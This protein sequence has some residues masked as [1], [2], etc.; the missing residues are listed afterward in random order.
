MIERLAWGFCG[1][2]A[3]IFL[4]LYL[5]G[6]ALAISAP[7][8][9]EYEGPCLWA[10]IQLSHGLDIYNPLRLLEP[11]YQVIIYPPV[12][13]LLCVPFQVFAG[14]SYW[15]LRLVSI[16]SFI[17][18]AVSSYRIFHRS[19]NSIYA[20]IVGLIAYS[21][22]LPIWSWSIKGRVDMLS[23]SLSIVAIDLFLVAYQKSDTDGQESK[24]FAGR[25]L[26]HLG[27]YT[28]FIICCVLAIFTKQPAVMIPIAV[29]IFLLTKRKFLDFFIIAIGSG[30]LSALSLFA[31]DLWTRGGFMQHMRFLSRMPFSF[32]DLNLHLAWMGS[33]WGK[34]LLIPIAILF[35]RRRKDESMDTT[36]PVALILLSGL[37]TFYS[38][39]TM[40]ANVN[41]AMQFYWAA[42]WLLAICA[43]VAPRK[44]SY[45]ILMA[46]LLSAYAIFSTFPNLRNVTSKMQSSMT[47]LEKEE[48]TGTTMFVEDPALALEVGAEPLFVDVATFIQV[49]E[50]EGRNLDHLLNNIKDT[51]YSAI[52]INRH[53]SQLEKPP[54][55]W[56]TK[57]IDT[58]RQYYKYQGKV[59]GNGEIQDLFIVKEEYK[60][61]RAP[62][63]VK[64]PVSDEAQKKS[65]SAEPHQ[66]AE[67]ESNS[68]SKSNSPSDASTRD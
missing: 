68:N 39:G 60:N 5:M 9:I 65:G 16:L 3:L 43:A 55:F 17:I 67:A 59:V 48:L 25:A 4:V 22:F 56:P 51:K 24:S 31:I 64:S 8:S 29:A 47:L 34:L 66:Q 52:V 12:F 18:S 13:F 32:N 1:L 49:W 44:L 54:Y 50:R 7:L 62:E 37:L 35:L 28:L 23:V 30:G 15:G 61:S 36:L 2:V 19:T 58:I 38:L 40:Y 33:D 53:D 10:T 14:T 46:S 63:Q 27:I 21:S 6:W 42:A 45:A 26:H 41:H 57:M 11:P 20:S